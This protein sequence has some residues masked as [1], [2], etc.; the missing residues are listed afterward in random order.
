MK[1]S[2]KACKTKRILI[3]GFNL[4]YKFPELAE[5]MYKGELNAAMNKLL[6][7][8][9]DYKQKKKKDITVIFDGKKEEGSSLMKEKVNG[10]K[11]R[12]S[13][14]YSADFIIMSIIKND[15]EPR[16]ITVVTS[17]KEILFFLNRYFTPSIKSEDFSEM[18]KEELTEKPDLEPEKK[19]DVKLDEEEISFWQKLFNEKK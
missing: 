9:K 19:E 16:M 5:H 13:H 8:L 10:I 2:L 15:K 1:N 4:I 18:I 12:Y 14:D 11:V 17:D 7:I 6:G 3:D